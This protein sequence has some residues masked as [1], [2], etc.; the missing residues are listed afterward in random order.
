MKSSKLLKYKNKKKGFL[1]KKRNQH[2]GIPPSNS[3]SIKNKNK[4]LIDG[5]GGESVVDTDV[6]SVVSNIKSNL[7]EKNTENSLFYRETEDDLKIDDEKIDEIIRI[8]NNIV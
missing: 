4:I 5:I 7:Q 8:Y 1:T 2:G 6:G 3:S